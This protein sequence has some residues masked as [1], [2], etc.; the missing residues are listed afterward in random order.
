MNI[1]D[2]NPFLRFASQMR[3]DMRYNQKM[4]LVTDCRI[5]YVID[6]TLTINTAGK[7]HT[8]SSGDLFYFSAGSKYTIDTSKGFTLFCLNFD[9][10]QAH[11]EHA[12][13]IAPTWDTEKWKTVPIFSE[14]VSNSHFLG[15]FLFLKNAVYLQDQMEKIVSDFV[16]SNVLGKELSSARLKLLLT[17]MHGIASQDLP[18]SVVRVRAYIEKHYTRNITNQ[19]MAELVGYHEHY[20]N[21]LFVKC[22]GTSLHNYLLKHRLTQA[23][24]LILNTDLPLQ[25]IAAQTGFNNYSNFYISYKNHYGYTPHEY[26]K[27]LKGT[28]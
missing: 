9:L 25:D 7:L 13:P 12:F 28:F 11:R 22:M 17:K 18:E 23:N 2:L 15:S 4:V 10:T 21:R 3:F 5:F 27:L 16:S 6:G 1:H 8:M 19:E 14:E 24:Y 20:L 26:R